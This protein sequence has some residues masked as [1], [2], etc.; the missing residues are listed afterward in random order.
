[1][2]ILV[3]F[4]SILVQSR[5]SQSSSM[6]FRA[7]RVSVGAIYNQNRV[8]FLKKRIKVVSDKYHYDVAEPDQKCVS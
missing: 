7:Q 8:C 5:S 1:M 6:I 3:F 4:W 2:V